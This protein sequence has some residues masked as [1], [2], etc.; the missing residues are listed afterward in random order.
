MI[1]I[2]CLLSSNT[3]SSDLAA[4][5]IAVGFGILDEEG[6]YTRS[7]PNYVLLVEYN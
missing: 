7:T 3:L 2:N 1:T 5:D 6:C 4:L